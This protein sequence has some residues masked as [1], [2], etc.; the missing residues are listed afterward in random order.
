MRLQKDAYGCTTAFTLR[1]RNIPGGKENEREDQVSTSS[2]ACALRFRK[3]AR[4]REN[5]REDQV[6]TSSA[7][8]A[9]RFRKIAR[10]RESPIPISSTVT[11]I[12]TV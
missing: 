1:F 12:K 8:C 3:I 10:R 9:L 2:A 4:R 5:E 7:A 11:Y 6:S